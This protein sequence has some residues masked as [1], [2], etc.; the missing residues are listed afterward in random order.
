VATV[1]EPITGEL[2]ANP[3]AI[4]AKFEL[5]EGEIIAMNERVASLV[6]ADKQSRAA[7]WE[8]R[9]LFRKLRLSVK[10]REESLTEEAKAQI[11]SVKEV[12]NVLIGMLTPGE[13]AI[14]A[15]IDAYDAKIEQAKRQAEEAKKLA[16]Q[17][18]LDALLAVGAM[19]HPLIVEE[20]DEAEFQSELQTATHAF[21]TKRIREQEEAEKAAR[22]EAE[23]LEA[24]R[25]EQEKLA[26]ERAEFQRQQEE[27][28]AIEWER[29]VRAK[30]EEERIAAEK[31]AEQAKIDEANRIE[32]EAIE[33]QRKAVQAERDRL[34]R[35]E[36]LRQ[37][38]IREEQEAAER[39][40]QEQLEAERV[41]AIK[42][43]QERLALIAEAEEKARIEAIKPDIEKI[44]AFG[45]VL[46]LLPFP[47]CVSDDAQAF[48]RTMKQTIDM[49]AMYCEDFE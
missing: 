9:Q 43:E 26:A 34:H 32:R 10:K 33:A 21:E 19:M 28:E 36:F 5:N 3:N 25:I 49:W 39:L 37:S 8:D 2:M 24:L 22:I 47:D 18:R 38:K 20:W 31:A 1:L 46:R 12:A 29:R 27:L 40:K 44:R 30:I 6:V 35:E 48:V 17:K 15:K 23:R 45:D 13:E 4:R 7:A 14:V 42:A 41:A 16:V 11:K